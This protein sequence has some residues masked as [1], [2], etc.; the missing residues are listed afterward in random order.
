MFFFQLLYPFARVNNPMCRT[1]AAAGEYIL[2]RRRALLRV[3]GI[4]AVRGALI[5]DVALA[6]AVKTGGRIFL[7]HSELARSIRP[8]PAAADIWNMIARSAYAQLRFSPA[9]LIATTL[10][11]ALVWLRTARRRSVRSWP[12]T[13]SRHFHLG[14]VRRILPADFGP[15]STVVPL[16]PAAAG[17]R[18][19]STWP[20]PSARR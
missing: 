14:H 2:L 20:R 7:G 9:V 13:I 6:A 19:C 16:G 15:V 17:D 5:D 10:A 4:E 8:Y 1:A 18:R 12:H 3:G 11:M